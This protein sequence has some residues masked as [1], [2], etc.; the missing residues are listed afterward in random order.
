[1]L[2]LKPATLPIQSTFSQVQHYTVLQNEKHKSQ[3]WDRDALLILN[4]RMRLR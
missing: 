3:F 2:I 4:G 1:M